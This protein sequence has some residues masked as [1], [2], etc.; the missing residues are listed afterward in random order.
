MKALQ[1]R[2]EQYNIYDVPRPGGLD[3]DGACIII[4]AVSLYCRNQRIT[5]EKARGGKLLGRSLIIANKLGLP[6]A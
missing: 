2:C 1:G 3:G 6:Q 5:R 4:I